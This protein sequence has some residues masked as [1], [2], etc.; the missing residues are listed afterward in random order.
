MVSSRHRNEC[1][2]SPHIRNPKQSP[3]FADFLESSIITGDAC[4]TRK[5][6]I[7]A[8]SNVRKTQNL[9]STRANNASPMQR[10][11][12][13]SRPRHYWPLPKTLR[14]TS[15]APL[16]IKKK[17]DHKN[18]P[19]SF[20]ESCLVPSGTIV[21]MTGN[22]VPDFFPKTF[23]Q[24]TFWTKLFFRMAFFQKFFPSKFFFFLIGFIPKLFFSEWH[25]F[26]KLFLRNF[27]LR[28]VS[29]RIGF[30]PKLFFF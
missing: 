20:Q 12:P 4:P 13:T 26:R 11:T 14:I 8:K 5:W 9:P 30:F 21:R 7:G 27:F 24:I 17:I 29:F 6:R 23:L 19:A 22:A 25:F 18:P 3:T 28:I 15:L 16:S 1:R 2:Q 10:A